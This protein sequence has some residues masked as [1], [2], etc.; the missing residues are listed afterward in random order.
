MI[1]SYFQI[2]T[3]MGERCVKILQYTE[4]NNIPYG[5]WSFSDFEYLCD[6]QGA[7]CDDLNIIR[8]SKQHEINLWDS[9]WLNSNELSM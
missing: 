9:W 3:N 2:K 7:V 8:K 5:I 6:F 4:D 1:G